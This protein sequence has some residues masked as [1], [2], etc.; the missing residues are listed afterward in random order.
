MEGE[1]E[2]AYSQTDGAGDHEGCTTS[3]AQL[4]QQECG[5]L[6][7]DQVTTKPAQPLEQAGLGLPREGSGHVSP[8]HTE[9]LEQTGEILNG[10]KQLAGKKPRAQ[11]FGR[12]FVICGGNAGPL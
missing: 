4:L 1:G 11:N 3:S 9:S 5:V 12:L 10:N 2:A 6:L 8:A 7:S